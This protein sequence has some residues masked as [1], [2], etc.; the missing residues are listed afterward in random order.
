MTAKVTQIIKRGEVWLAN[1]GDSV[2]SEQSGTRP[3]LI[4]SNNKN[5]I[6]STT[7]TIIPLTSKHNKNNIP[8]Q[9]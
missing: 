5:N 3:V 7:V 2:G 4:V 9:H 1:L 6:Y 8:T